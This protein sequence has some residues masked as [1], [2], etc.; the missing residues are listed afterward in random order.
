MPKWSNDSYLQEN[1]VLQTTCTL[2][3]TY[4]IN[5]VNSNL[6]IHLTEITRFQKHV[7]GLRTDMQ[8]PRQNILP[9]K[10][11]RIHSFNISF[12]YTVLSYETHIYFLGNR[13]FFLKN[14]IAQT[15]G[16]H[17]PK[18]TGNSFDLLKPKSYLSRFEDTARHVK[19]THYLPLLQFCQTLLS[20]Y[21]STNFSLELQKFN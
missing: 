1:Q 21:F 20:S 5:F 19:S 12:L 15:F 16:S 9:C 8:I 14:G 6:F 11:L 18:V 10:K 4:Q 2:S 13:K 7:D 17:L 3:M